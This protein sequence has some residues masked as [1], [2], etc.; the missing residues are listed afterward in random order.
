STRDGRP[1]HANTRAAGPW[2]PKPPPR[3]PPTRRDERFLRDHTPPRRSGQRRR[4]PPPPSHHAP[5]LPTRTRA[6][7]SKPSQVHRGRRSNRTPL[8]E[9]MRV[10]RHLAESTDAPLPADLQEACEALLNDPKT[11]QLVL[12]LLHRSRNSS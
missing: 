5:Q 4:T 9:L 6:S 10:V 2:R 11:A 8:P 12:D 7:T 3:R 1:L